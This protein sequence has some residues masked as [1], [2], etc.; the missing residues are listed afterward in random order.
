MG[1]LGAAPQTGEFNP[2]EFEPAPF[3]LYDTQVA[4]VKAEKALEHVAASRWSEAIA[5]LQGLI[6]E[7]RGEVL[8]AERPK[9][10]DART[11]SQTDVHAGAGTWAVRQLFDLPSEGKELYRARFG[12]RAKDSLR[13][14]IAASDRGGL[15]RVARRWPLTPAA[16]RA[17]WALGDLEVEL[18]HAADGVR[19]W[20]RAA[21]I[22]VGDPTRSTIERHE[23]EALR[24]EV[25]A[26][27]DPTSH[28]GALARIDLSLQLRES[29]GDSGG[30]RKEDE[31]S[32]VTGP[33][34]GIAAE[35]LVITTPFAGTT[36]A[37]APTG[38]ESALRL[39]Q[40]PFSNGQGGGRLFPV[41]L[42]DTIFVNTSRSVHAIDAFDGKERWTMPE[43]RVGW[44]RLSRRE[45]RDFDQA[46]DKE[47]HI[48]SLSASR[49]VVVAPVQIPWIYQ[50]SD[51]YNDLQII[52]V[53]PERRLIALDAETGEELW[54][55]LPPKNWDGDSGT[56]AES[57]TVVGPPT[58]VGARV[59]VPMAKLRGRIELHL[60]C[61]DLDTG[62]VLWSAPLVTGQRTLNMFGRANTEFSAPSTVVVGDTAIQLTQLGIVAAVDIFTGETR[63]DTVYNQVSIK[64]P[65]YYSP[66]TIDNR[67]H[68]APPVVTGDTLVAAPYD[69]KS[70]FALDIES[71]AM[72]WSVDQ[73][74]LS[75]H[76]IRLNRNSPRTGLDIVLG[77]DQRH[78]ILGG[79]TIASIE[80]PNGVRQGPPY[81]RHWLWP[82]S[83]RPLNGN[84]GIPVLDDERVFA[85]AGQRIAAIE[86]DTGRVVEEIPGGIGEGNLL[87]SDGML[88]SLTGNR[89]DARFQWSAMVERARTALAG[90]DATLDDAA[91]LVR[92]LLE[93]AEL[94]VG[95]GGPVSKALVLL[96]EAGDVIEKQAGI[97]AASDDLQGEGASSATIPGSSAAADSLRS[98]LFEVRIL[99]GQAERLRGDVNAARE[100]TRQ[101]KSLATSEEQE[102]RALLTLHEIERTRDQV[103]RM[104]ILAELSSRRHRRARIGVRADLGRSRW[105]GSAELGAVLEAIKRGQD[106]EAAWTDPWTGP[107]FPTDALVRSKPKAGAFPVKGELAEGRMDCGLFAL[108]SEVEAARSLPKGSEDG[109]TL[110]LTALHNVL[111]DVPRE[112]IFGGPASTT[113]SQWAQA[114][115]R[116]L[117]VMYPTSPAFQAFEDQA[118][119]L[120][121][122]AITR[123][124]SPDGTTALLDAIPDLFPGSSAADRAADARIEVAL[125]SGRAADVAQIVVNSLDSNWHPATTSVREAELLAQLA[126][127]MGAE[128]N[129]ELQVGLLRNLAR[130]SPT[131]EI[132]APPSPEQPG[133]TSVTLAELR[134]QWDNE[135]SAVRTKPAPHQPGFNSSSIKRDSFKGDF[136]LVEKGEV[137]RRGGLD[138]AEPA[139]SLGE[140]GFFASDIRL[141][142][143]AS[144]AGGA[145]LWQRPESLSINPS[146][147]PRRVTLAGGSSLI[148][149]RDHQVA[150]IDAASGE[151]M[152]TFRQPGR[153]IGRIAVSG[154]MVVV[155][156][157]DAASRAVADIYGIDT[158]KGLELWRL[159]DIGSSYH[160]TMLID[161]GRLILLPQSQSLAAVHDLYT[162]HPVAG[163][164]TGRLRERIALYSWADRGQLVVAHLDGARSRDQANAI[165]AYDLDNGKEVWKIDLDRHPGGMKNL[166]SVIDM[167]AEEG[168][169]KRV[170]IAL[171]EPAEEGQRSSGLRKPPFDLYIL[172][173][174]LGALDQRPLASIDTDTRLVSV[175][176]HRREVIESPLLIAFVSGTARRQPTIRAIHPKL[177]RIW[178]V[179]APKNM[180]T[181]AAT[182]L[183]EPAFGDGTMAL[184]VSESVSTKGSNTAM[185]LLFLDAASGSLL[186][187]RG[188]PVAARSSVPREIASFGSALAVCAKNIM[189]I[190]E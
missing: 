154:G 107:V 129:R 106:P 64:A 127:T 65:R 2:D 174:R 162:G 27:A 86:R 70:M 130:Y 115:I 99:R 100:A 9:P 138:R 178:E 175:R 185:R 103:A 182:G 123:A 71:G 68:N 189:E 87:V 133:P 118:D 153:T 110:E 76:V 104:E 23:W 11:P 159:Q 14:A 66:G 48:V 32:F 135:L 186:E 61:F 143:F 111:R 7:H 179:Q 177:G 152:W 43:S 77:A 24:A 132:Q 188:F 82:A 142:A 18:G 17:W 50:E 98:D 30:T 34:L 28:A 96:T 160:Q 56:F 169:K 45:L 176:N 69:G 49:G 15:A 173:E 184:M 79:S 37:E 122:E 33:A 59:L 120:L 83:P 119:E 51:Q 5:E 93:R 60:G 95:R 190:M 147:R 137:L 75:D 91:T 26:M 181:T 187:S 125:E 121:T 31:A 145:P 78:V 108:I 166:L 80:F 139:E 113:S 22:H 85:P 170:R 10:T 141:M 114:R 74:R 36:T 62:R 164:S 57:M 81:Q 58:I 167:P 29:I 161:S 165:V 146:H 84:E 41:R 102:R 109:L 72:L 140:V 92:L 94:T 53:I 168:S 149:Q 163:I 19:A 46:I 40:N 1:S 172:N 171:L 101:A 89:L 16:E 44:D 52:E 136:T 4:R 128:G 156:T 158:V 148:V 124:K 131:L 42:G 3:H 126:K 150:C 8:A 183:P 12:P 73:K 67:W 144:G 6:E 54:N 38:W 35:S 63:W 13:R 117:R 55:T 88:F 105:S 112:R 116:A 90:A 180:R 47:E 134:D 151:E 25:A 20:G 157:I 39:P 21:A 155:M 97:R